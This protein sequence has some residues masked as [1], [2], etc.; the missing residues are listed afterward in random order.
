M[1]L[2]AIPEWI[3]WRGPVKENVEPGNPLAI[4]CSDA[5]PK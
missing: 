4:T 5:R 2:I 3:L 1:R